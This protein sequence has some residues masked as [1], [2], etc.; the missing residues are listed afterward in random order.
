MRDAAS[1]IHSFAGMRALVLGEAMLDRY[2]TGVGKRICPEAPV[3]VIDNCST[4]NFAGG[5]ANTAVNLRS[6]GAAVTF[7]SVAGSDAEGAVLQEILERHEIDLPGL[8]IAPERRTLCKH[9]VLASAQMM[10][11]FDQGTTTAISDDVESQ[12]VRDLERLGRH[13]DLIV[14]SDYNYGVITPRVVATLGALR[15]DGS[16]VLAVDSRRLPQFRQL[17]AT[18]VKPN[19]AETLALLGDAT[20]EPAERRD[21]VLARG[22][23]ILRRSGAQIAAVTLD[24]DGAVVLERNAAP[25]RTAAT[26]APNNQAG[27]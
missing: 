21:Y 11:R 8:R 4:V 25:Y 3:P 13:A 2:S 27:G 7:L 17:G 24:E 15:R 9:R 22:A 23:E 16:Q 5:A 26:P 10:L 6:L 1:I 20:A 12:L 14:V 18:V 19:F